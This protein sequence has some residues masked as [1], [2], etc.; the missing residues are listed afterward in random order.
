M[1]P[2]WIEMHLDLPAAAIDLVGSELAELGCEGLTV[3]ERQ[4][5]TF[6]PPDPHEEPTPGIH[7][8]KAYFPLTEGLETLLARVRERLV[9]LDA[10]VPGL[11]EAPLTTHPVGQEDWAE[12]WKQHFPAVRIGRHLLI[13]PSWEQVEAEPGDAVL[14]LDPGMAFGTGT[15]GTTRLCLEAIAELYA[16]PGAPLRVLDVGTGS[17]I[18][19]MAAAALGAQRVLACD[20]DE[21]SCSTARENVALNDLEAR[22]DITATPLEQLEGN[23]DLVVANIL[24]EENVRLA[25]ELVTRVAPGGWLILSG[26]LQEREAFVIQGFAPFL[27]QGPQ[28]SRRQEWSCLTY[29]KLT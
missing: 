25:A 20:I 1:T 26:I 16:G 28:L 27:L 8:I 21:Q 3:E 9:W 12:N 15:H 2:T 5:D 23:F 19:A 11:A 29:R 24:A 4:L 22:I 10:L 7:R 6:I 17:G 18:L 14:T 13:R